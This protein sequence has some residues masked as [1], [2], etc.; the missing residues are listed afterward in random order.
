MDF[1]ARLARKRFQLTTR[2]GI[3]KL[4]NILRI[5]RKRN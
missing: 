5:L 1:I 4:R 2:N 3:Q